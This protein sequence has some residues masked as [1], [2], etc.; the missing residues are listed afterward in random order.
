MMDANSKI[1]IGDA[2]RAM[3]TFIDTYWQRG[4]QSDDQIANLLSAMQFG[5]EITPTKTIDPSYFFFCL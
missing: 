5:E 2:Y 1:S 4:G 3:F